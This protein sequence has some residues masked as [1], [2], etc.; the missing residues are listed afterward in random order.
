MDQE[1]KVRENRLRRSADRQ[2]FALRKSGRRDP[3]AIDYGA[4]ALVDPDTGLVVAGTTA[5]GR[6]NFTLDDVEAWLNGD[7]S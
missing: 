2:G 5:A 6:F 7:R 4:Y 3:R 1:T